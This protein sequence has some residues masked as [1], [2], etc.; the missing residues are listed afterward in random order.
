MSI[1]YNTVVPGYFE[2][3]KIPILRGRAFAEQDDS[4]TQSALVIN[5]RFAQRF[6][7]GGDAVGKVV[8]A[9]GRDHI[10]IGVVPTGKYKSLG[11][12]PTAYMYYVQAQRWSSSMNLHIRTEGNPEA[13]VPALRSELAALDPS[14]P[15][16]NVRTL[17]NYL[18]TSLLPARLV[19][20][21]LGVFGLLGLILAAVGMY[22]VMAYSVT[23]RTREIGIRMAIGAASAQVISMVMR[24]GMSL[25]IVGSLV[26]L[27]GAV[28]ASQLVRGLLIGGAAIDLVS[29]AVVPL[30]LIAVAM[31]AVWVPA[32]R[33]SSVNPVTALRTE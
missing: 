1:Y 26:G 17:N 21:V 28:G 4:L 29:F 9:R 31:L 13:I 10:V 8:R 6:W 2:A 25:V 33:A 23:Q 14:M 16:A 22:G 19:G 24:Q 12:E 18:G 32:R 5:E 3:L 7:P 15:L 11:E 30:V 20:G 27:A